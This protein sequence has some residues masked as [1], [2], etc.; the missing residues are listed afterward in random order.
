MKKSKVC[1]CGDL[2][3]TLLGA[4][5][6]IFLVLWGISLNT[7]ID[8]LDVVNESFSEFER[9]DFDYCVEWNDFIERDRLFLSCFDFENNV[10]V[11]DWSVLDNGSL[12][13]SFVDERVEMYDCSHYL[14]SRGIE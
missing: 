14:M 13:V 11:C 4:G 7:T 9:A 1:D 3:W 2:F 8:V 12:R 5:L 10:F 6:C